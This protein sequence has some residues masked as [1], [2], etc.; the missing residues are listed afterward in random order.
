MI[1]QSTPMRLRLTLVALLPAL[2]LVFATLLGL[3]PFRLLDL[4]PVM[5]AFPLIVVWYFGIERPDLLPAWAVF[6]IGVLGDLLAQAPLG[7]GGILLVAVHWA[8]SSQRRFFL[9]EPFMMFWLGFLMVGSAALL[10]EWL[11]TMAWLFAFIDPIPM[12]VKIA[13]T[14]ALCPPVAWLLVRLNRIL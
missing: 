6:V 7:L 11:L 13:L 3:V 2:C 1:P 9:R 14:N 12:L 4:G 8:A 10:L 5:P